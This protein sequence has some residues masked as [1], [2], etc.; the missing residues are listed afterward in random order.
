MFS[1][2]LFLKILMLVTI[3]GL[4]DLYKYGPFNIISVNV[5][6]KGGKATGD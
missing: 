5:E 6:Q 2:F 4:I 1:F 3:I